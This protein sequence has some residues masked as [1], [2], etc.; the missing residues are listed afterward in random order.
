VLEKGIKERERRKCMVVR[1]SVAKRSIVNQLIMKIFFEILGYS[2]PY[3][4]S[5]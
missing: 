4:T 3:T 2:K 5:L 1:Y